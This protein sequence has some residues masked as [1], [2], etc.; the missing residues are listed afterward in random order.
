ML[1][2]R[3]EIVHVVQI[4]SSCSTLLLLVL[5][6]SDSFHMFRTVL[7]VVHFFLENGFT[8]LKTNCSLHLFPLVVGSVGLIELV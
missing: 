6:R 7:D 8:M 2:G 1:F 4:A 5:G 3:S